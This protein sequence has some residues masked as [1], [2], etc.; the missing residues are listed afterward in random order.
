MHFEQVLKWIVQDTQV[1]C[2][3]MP[4]RIFATE[5]FAIDSFVV[6]VAHYTQN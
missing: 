2:A 4:S 3:N 5:M 6:Y 1:V